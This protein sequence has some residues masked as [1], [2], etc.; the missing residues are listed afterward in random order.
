MSVITRRSARNLR[1]LTSSAASDV[2]DRVV[3]RTQGTV[4]KSPN[5]IDREGSELCQRDYTLNMDKAIQKKIDAC[6]LEFKV[7]SEQKGENFVFCFSTAMYELYRNAL[8]E[9]FETMKNET[10]KNIKIEYKDCSD[11]SGATVES[12]IRIFQKNG[13]KLKFTINMYHTKSKVMVNGKEAHRFSQEHFSIT[14][15]VLQSE[16]VNKLD[17]HIRNKLLDDLNSLMADEPSAGLNNNPNHD[18]VQTSS[19]R[20]P[21][22]PVMGQSRGPLD[23]SDNE[24]TGDVSPCPACEESVIVDGIFCDLCEN[25][26]HYHCENLSSG[27]IETLTCSDDPYHCQFCVFD[28]ECRNFD[29]H[30][31]DLEDLS[32]LTNDR[33]IEEN[34][35]SHIDQNT[36]VKTISPT[37]SPVPVL[38]NLPYKCKTVPVSCSLMEDSLLDKTILPLNHLKL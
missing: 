14:T 16:D 33:N 34:D 22:Q 5:M 21:V 26:F 29:S 13:K 28:S 20:P 17:K 9:H 4:I 27:E 36:H 31:R 18:T 35:P 10:Q 3:Q 37:P 25:W 38:E 8:V 30:C 7:Q 23:L 12:Q 19:L 2:P 24:D 32:S 15:R 1:N 6:S 11:K